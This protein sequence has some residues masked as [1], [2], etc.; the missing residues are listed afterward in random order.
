MNLPLVRVSETIDAN[1]LRVEPVRVGFVSPG[2]GT[3]YRHVTV[4]EDDDPL[5][6]VDVYPYEP[7]S[8]AFQ[9]AVVWRGSL[10][11]GVGSHVHA[12]S[13]A[14]RSAVTV[15]LGWLFRPLLSDARLSLARLVRA[16]VPHG[17][18]SFDS[19]AECAAGRRRG[20]GQRSGP[21]RR[22]G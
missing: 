2:V 1:W 10:I 9:A 19:L 4:G 22:S 18:R 12:I 15:A 17:A 13:I 8:F 20:R 5:L 16:S 11:V 3:P 7:D 21:A 6:R 14:D